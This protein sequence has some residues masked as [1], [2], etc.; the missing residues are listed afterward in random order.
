MKTRV[1]PF[2]KLHNQWLAVRS[3]GK[4]QLHQEPARSGPSP[5]ATSDI[6]PGSAS[7]PQDLLDSLLCRVRANRL[8]IVAQTVVLY[9]PI[10]AG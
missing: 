6:E 10:I 8:D 7:G 5:G 3:P 9:C 1:H 4:V 2:N